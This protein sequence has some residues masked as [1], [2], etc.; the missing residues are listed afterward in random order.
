MRPFQK[1]RPG[2]RRGEN[3]EEGGKENPEC[4]NLPKENEFFKKWLNYTDLVRL[5]LQSAKQKLGTFDP[6]SVFKHIFKKLN[7]Y[8]PE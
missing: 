4:G 2:L 6:N 8:V 3:G 1:L 7:I 5:L